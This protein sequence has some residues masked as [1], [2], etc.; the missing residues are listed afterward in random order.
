LYQQ[1]RGHSNYGAGKLTARR[2]TLPEELCYNR[3]MSEDPIATLLA[4]A[5]RAG[6]A[7]QAN[8]LIAEAR[9]E[10]L[11]QHGQVVQAEVIL[12]G[13]SWEYLVTEAA[14]RLALYLRSKKLTVARCAPGLVSVFLGETLHFLHARDFFEAIR[15][16]EGHSEQAFTRIAEAWEQTGRAPE[17]NVL[18]LRPPE[19][20]DDGSR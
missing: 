19:G 17:A 4:C 13:R 8:E 20:G 14:P 10:I 7:L 18:A 9:E 3:E 12:T 16:I 15:R 11:A 1:V 2:L 5:Y 6:P